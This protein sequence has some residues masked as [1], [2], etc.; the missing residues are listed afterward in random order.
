MT[1]REVKDLENRVSKLNDKSDCCFSGELYVADGTLLKIF[2][3]DI[4]NRLT[5]FVKRQR[6]QFGKV[7]SWMELLDGMSDEEQMTLAKAITQLASP[8]RRSIPFTF[9]IETKFN[10]TPRGCAVGAG[11]GTRTHEGLRHRIS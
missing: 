8:L 6:R 7:H 5:E 2:P 11:G 10:K 4:G 1:K 9:Q 3:A